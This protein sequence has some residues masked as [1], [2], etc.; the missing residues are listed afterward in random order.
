MGPTSSV[1]VIE[2]LSLGLPVVTTRHHGMA[3]M[4]DE[5]CGFPLRVDS[6]SQLVDDLT[7]SLRTLA[8]DRATLH[9]LSAGA[10]RRAEH[11]SRDRQIQAIDSLYREASAAS[12]G[13]RR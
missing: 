6:P 2:A 1:V 13:P 11:F 9:R 5:T 8:L 4:I 10:R 12:G 7:D 3:D